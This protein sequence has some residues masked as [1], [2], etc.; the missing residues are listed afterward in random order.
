MRR[1]QALARNG[2][3]DI[4]KTLKDKEN[5]LALQLLPATLA[6][7]DAQPDAAVRLELA[8]RGVFAGNGE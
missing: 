1:D 8:L 2:F 4:F 7:L 5:D 6:E 3:G